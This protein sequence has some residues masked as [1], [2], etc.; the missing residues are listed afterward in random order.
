MAKD[1]EQRYTT[2]GQVA[3]ALR[4][5]QQK[6]AAPEEDE[7]DAHPD[8]E[9]ARVLVVDDLRPIRFFFKSTLSKANADVSEAEN[10]LEALQALMDASERGEP[11]DLLITDV[12][13]PKMGGLELLERLRSDPDLR[14]TPVI[15]ITTEEDQTVVLKFARLGISSYLAKP[16]KGKQVLEVAKQALDASE[17]SRAHRSSA[18]SRD[19]LSVEQVNELYGLVTENMEQEVAQSA[20]PMSAIFESPVY[21]QF[22]EFLQRHC[23]EAV[24]D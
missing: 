8:L 20:C 2:A 9:D 6:R 4:R 14:E 19:G 13:M 12:H 10:G 5:I 1:P 15:V 11:F 7:A 3:E 23:P 16:P 21:V 18:A 22:I 24:K 17:A